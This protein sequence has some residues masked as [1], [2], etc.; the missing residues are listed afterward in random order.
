MMATRKPK[1]A[2][3]KHSQKEQK[4]SSSEEIELKDQGRSYERDMLLFQCFLVMIYLAWDN[5]ISVM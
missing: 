4:T 3:S 1:I 2:P 5:I